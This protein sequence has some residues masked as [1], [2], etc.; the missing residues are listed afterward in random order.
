MN[1][2]KISFCIPTYNRS[3]LLSEL[4]ESIVSQVRT[5]HCHEI[6]I[7]VSDNNSSDDTTLMVAEWQSR[8]AV[9]IVY[10]KSEVNVGPDL[11]YMRAVGLARGEYCWYFGSD[12]ILAVGALE[13]MLSHLLDGADIYLCNRVACDIAM[14]RIDDEYW[15]VPTENSRR[16]DFANEVDF[17]SYLSKATG[18][19]ALFSFLSSIVFRRERWNTIELDPSYIGSAYSHV[20]KLL[21]FRESGCNFI[22]LKDHF[23][24]CRGG[25]DTF[26]D[27]GILRR[28][29]LDYDGY[30]K[31]ARDIFEVNGATY[32]SFLAVLRRH[33]PALRTLRS[34]VIRAERKEWKGLKATL[35]NVGY[36][37]ML[38]DLFW[39]ISPFLRAA[40]FFKIATNR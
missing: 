21:K 27:K 29:F 23:V 17:I 3:S 10:S 9:R 6:E 25:N 18:V 35:I 4:I 12:D 15:L 34:I 33:H 30:L 5:E 36:N 22:Y 20:Y 8:S 19:G 37:G 39:W 24:L 14:N 38:C 11:N 26:M 31:L 1:N 40:Y 2:I 16:Y 13:G 7:C 32:V 28:I